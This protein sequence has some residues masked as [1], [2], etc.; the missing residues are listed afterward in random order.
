MIGK[1]T[2]TSRGDPLG[3]GLRERSV[4]VGVWP[5]L[6]VCACNGTYFLQSWEQPHRPV[7][8]AVCVLAALGSI[9]IGRLPVDAIVRSRWC[10]PFFLAWSGSLAGLIAVGSLLDGG[11]ASP[12]T[13]QF[14]LPLAFAALSYPLGTMLGVVAMTVVAFLAVATLGAAPTGAPAG[15][16]MVFTLTLVT[17]GW[18]CA[19][20]A[21]NRDVQQRALAEI[22]RTDHLTGSLNRRGFE[23]R[24]AA[25]VDAASRHDGALSLVLFDLDGFKA[26]NDRG[27]HAAGDELLCWVADTLG[28]QVRS[29]DPV[30]RLGGDE[31]AVVLSHDTQLVAPTVDRLVEVLGRRTSASVGVADYPADGVELDELHR[32]ADEALYRCKRS[33]RGEAAKAES[34]ELSSPSAVARAAGVRVDPAL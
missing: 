31:F 21:R 33:R 25:E 24:F 30:G 19:W 7:A 13:V 20:Q 17:A 29:S 23:E 8:L 6:L 1:G 14:F 12:L 16:V 26:V 2:G 11:V 18:V 5:S 34:R 4:R 15:D 28:E 9:G 10:E 32:R 22:S 3:A 27:G